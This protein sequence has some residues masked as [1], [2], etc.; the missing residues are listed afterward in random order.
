MSA[1]FARVVRQALVTFERENCPL[2]KANFQTLKELVD[3]L[4]SV[5]LNIDFDA[6]KKV[7]N[8]SHDA[9]SREAAPVI[10]IDILEH[11]TVSMSVFILSKQYAMPAHDHPGYGLLKV[12][13]GSARI[14]SYSLDVPHEKPAAMAVTEEEPLVVTAHTECSVL[15]P[16][17][18]N[19]HEITA[20][21]DDS[22]AFFDILSPP[23]DS[24]I[25]VFGP[26]KCSFYR[27]MPIIPPL[28]T[29]RSANERRAY[30]QRIKCPGHYYCDSIRYRRPD[31]LNDP[32]FFNI[33]A[34]GVC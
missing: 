27:K 6:I 2:F 33:H 21:G 15:T 11:K 29:T 25:S 13:D 16:T 9:I 22:V 31:F 4:T 12:L 17:K 32:E 5:D 18:R 28:D 1:Q 19:I 24:K 7:F 10:Y 34:G 30:L 3:Q 8:Q 14:Q 20:V 23:Y 26:K